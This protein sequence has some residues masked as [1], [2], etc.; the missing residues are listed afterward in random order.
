MMDILFAV[1][2]LLVAGVV[3]VAIIFYCKNKYQNVSAEKTDEHNDDA[4]QTSQK[5]SEGKHVAYG[6]SFG[7]CIGAG[8]G[9]VLMAFGILGINA[10]VYGSCFGML[11]GL[12]VGLCFE[13]PQVSNGVK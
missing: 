9:S 2:P 13:K 3:V 1:L 12:I 7:T 4:S 6:I 8:I 10:L 11:A 5:R